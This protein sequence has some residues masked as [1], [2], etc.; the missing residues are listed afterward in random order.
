MSQFVVL[1]V[2]ILECNENLGFTFRHGVVKAVQFGCLIESDS[3][4][5]F[6]SLCGVHRVGRLNEFVFAVL[7]GGEKKP[8]VHS[9]SYHSLLTNQ[10]SAL[11]SVLS[12]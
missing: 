10:N 9:R 11:N 7:K 6:F 2:L 4:F 5:F 1:G 3:D 8:V 12:H